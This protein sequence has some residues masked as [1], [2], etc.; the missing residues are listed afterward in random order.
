M[1]NGN[2]GPGLGTSNHPSPDY[3]SVAPSTTTGTF[4]AGRFYASGPLPVDPALQRI[5]Y[6]EALFGSYFPV[7]GKY[8][9]LYKS[10]GLDR[11]WCEYRRLQPVGCRNLHRICRSDKT[12]LLPFLLQ[13][14]LC[15][16]GWSAFVVVYNNPADT[17]GCPDC[18]DTLIW[19]GT[20]A[21]S[22]QVTI[23][24]IFIGNTAGVGLVSWLTAHLT[25]AELTLDNIAYQSGNTP[26]ILPSFS[27]RGPGV[28]NVLKPDIAAPGVNILAQGEDTY[29][30]GRGAPPGLGPVFR[31]FDG[32]PPRR[33]RGGFA[34][35]DPS[36]VVECSDQVGLDVHF[37]LPGYLE[38]QRLARSALGYG[39]R[40]PGPD[41]RCRPGRHPGST[42]SELWNSD[43]RVGRQPACQ[44]HQCRQRDRDIFLE[45]HPGRRDLFH[46]HHQ[47]IAWGRYHAG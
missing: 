25:D 14:S 35:T 37:Q 45:C 43:D 15:A 11:R 4:S 5:P 7:G 36:R 1:S 2:S 16:T 6:L 21:V 46:N 26:D 19:M 12:R 22:N 38:L 3:I 42:F 32:C 33:R 27:S 39:R 8:P 28:G 34:Q 41:S 20:G 17:P 23:P 30:H 47:H 29:R 18:G 10:L 44:P 40:A 24:S 13:S 31:L 9:F